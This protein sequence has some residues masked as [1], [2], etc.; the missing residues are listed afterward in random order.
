MKVI[1][2]R[3]GSPQIERRFGFAVVRDAKLDERS[4]RI[5]VRN[6]GP[7]L[8][9]QPTELEKL[10]QKVQLEEQE[11]QGLHLRLREQMP[12]TSDASLT[13]IVGG[14]LRAQLRETTG[15]STTL[16]SGVAA[17]AASLE[18]TQQAKLRAQVY[19][20]AAEPC[21]V[22]AQVL[23]ERRDTA[24]QSL[25]M[26]AAGVAGLLDGMTVEAKN[27]QLTIEASAPAQEV[28]R[29]IEQLQ[30]WAKDA[31]NGTLGEPSRKTPLPDEVLRP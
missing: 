21:R 12:S 10:L 27:D 15:Q 25:A 11:P 18:L 14:D 4:A 30:Q 31:E 26:R 5:A 17:V 20:E 22:L 8:L 23:T 29:V 16:L 1:S 7:L 6:N 3:Q 19:C 28:A 2:E 9:G 13:V 24:R